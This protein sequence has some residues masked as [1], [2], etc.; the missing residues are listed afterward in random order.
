M[1]RVITA[2]VLT[3]ACVQGAAV[4]G[5]ASASAA[6]RPV[7]VNE[8][9]VTAPYSVVRPSLFY[10]TIGPITEFRGASWS[11]WGANAAAGTA[12]M[13]EIGFVTQNEGPARLK[14]YDVRNHGGT[15]YFSRLRVSGAKTGS[16]VWNWCYNLTNNFGEW[17]SSCP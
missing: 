10:L 5:S 9:G 11:S 3:A 8:P 17:Q 4:A 6:T 12:T 14:L 7:V 1:K 16:G 15:R 13:Y 2:V